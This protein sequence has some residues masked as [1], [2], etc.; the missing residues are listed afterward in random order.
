MIIAKG[1]K[2]GFSVQ[3]DFQKC[4]EKIA[5]SPNEFCNRWSNESMLCAML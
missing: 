4:R 1:P 5:A 3:T 2:Y